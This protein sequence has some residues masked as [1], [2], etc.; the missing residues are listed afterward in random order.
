MVTNATIRKASTERE[1]EEYR[2]AGRCFECGKQGHLARNCRN[3]RRHVRSVQ[4]EEENPTV[5]FEGEG[6]MSIRSFALVSLNS[7]DEREMQK[8]SEE[9]IGLKTA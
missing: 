7:F 8:L 4:I 6:D 3:K 9:G 5:G 2:K 1:R